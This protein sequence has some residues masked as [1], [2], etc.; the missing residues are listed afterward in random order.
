MITHTGHERIVHVAG[1]VPDTILLSNSHV[2]HLHRQEILDDRLP[3]ASVID[4]VGNTEDAGETL[5]IAHLIEARLTDIAEVG[6]EIAIAQKTPPDGRRHGTDNAFAISSDTNQLHFA[7]GG[8]TPV[9]LD[10]HTLR[11]LR[12]IADLRRLDDGRIA[13]GMI[14]RR[15][16]EP[17]HSTLR[18]T[19]GY[20]AAQHKPSVVV[21]HASV[22]EFQ[23]ASHRLHRDFLTEVVRT[24]GEAMANG[25]GFGND[26]VGTQRAISLAV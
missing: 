4:V 8:I 6:C 24:G 13:P 21:V 9:S 18:G 12:Q 17:A 14:N 23:I 16:D 2:A 11:L 22:V 5:A 3:Y 19:L 25:I 7:H 15:C 20:L 10:D 1:I 26:I